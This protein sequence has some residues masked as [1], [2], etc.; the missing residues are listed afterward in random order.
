MMMT[1][2]HFNAISHL[3]IGLLCFSIIEGSPAEPANP[4]ENARFWEHIYDDNRP[5]SFHFIFSEESWNEM[6]GNSSKRSQTNRPE[7][8]PPGRRAPQKFEYVE[9]DME[10]SGRRYEKIGIRYKG[11]SSFRSSRDSPRKPFKI[12]TNRYQK[13]LKLFG[14]TKLN[15]SN[16]FLDPAY[17]KEK[18]G[19]EV[20]RS[21]GLPAPG[22]GWAE[23]TY[24]VE[25]L[26]RKKRLGLYVII[27]QV[28]SNY[29]EKWFGK[30]SADSLLMKPESREDWRYLGTD[31]KAYDAFGFKYGKKQIGL[32]QKFAETLK[33]IESSTDEVFQ[34]E[35]GT[36]IDVENFAA[37]F[38][39]TALLVNLDSYVG[40]PHNYYLLL[41]KRDGLLKILP[42]DVNESFG[43]FTLNQDPARLIRWDIQRPWIAQRKLAERLFA[44]ESFRT[45]YLQQ[46]RNLLD[47]GFQEKRL[48]N[49]IRVLRKNIEPLLTHD[50]YGFGL[51][52]VEAGIRGDQNGLVPVVERRIPAI[53]PFIRKRT[54]SV[55]NQLAGKEA[56]ERIQP[57]WRR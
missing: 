28:D 43:T 14:E 44:T 45:L 24:S 27:E 21:A 55:K 20:Y 26:Y 10:V 3:C 15:F 7:R 12:D 16:A 49:R 34:K 52:G 42:W 39:A 31:P 6:N 41:D 33:M 23:V 54:E 48:I 18:L 30:D 57:R 25:G 19:Y 2:T 53:E 17:M 37:Y 51:E 56:G 9:A 47:N 29:I 22:V 38:A 4:S 46:L 36:Y 32:I 5:L 11:N 1:P 40:M 50:P 8:R 35:M 13:G